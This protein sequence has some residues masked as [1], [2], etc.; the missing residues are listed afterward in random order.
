MDH[1]SFHSIAGV[2]F[3]AIAILHLVRIV[4]GWD[5][6]IDK[7][8]VPMWVSYVVVAVAGYLSYSGLHLSRRS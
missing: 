2:I 6:V 4:Y 3:L 8:E 7:F 5:A 1:K